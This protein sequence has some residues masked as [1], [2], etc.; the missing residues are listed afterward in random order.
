MR[1]GFPFLILVILSIDFW[2]WKKAKPF[3]FGIPYWMWYIVSI[4]L[5]TAIFYALF[6]K[7]EWRED[8]D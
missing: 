2:N 8:N 4:V 6:A 5:L 7:Y 3:F 1:W